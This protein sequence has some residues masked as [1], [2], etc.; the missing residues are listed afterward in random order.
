MIKRADYVVDMDRGGIN[1][2]NWWVVRLSRWPLA[3]FIYGA[4]FKRITLKADLEAQLA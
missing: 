2:V 1:G 4:V 3:K